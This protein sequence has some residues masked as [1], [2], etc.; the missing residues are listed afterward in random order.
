MFTLTSLRIH[1]AF[2]PSFSRLAGKTHVLHIV[3]HN[4]GSV[5]TEWAEIETGLTEE[6]KAIAKSFDK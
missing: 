1:C 2:F 4:Y 6:L 5:L 3:C